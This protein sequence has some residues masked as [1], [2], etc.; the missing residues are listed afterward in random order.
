M[1][2]V[3]GMC[4]VHAC[5]QISAFLLI[6]LVLK[7]LSLNLI[8]LPLSFLP[9]GVSQGSQQ[10]VSQ[11]GAQY[12]TLNVLQQCGNLCHVIGPL[13]SSMIHTYA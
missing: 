10:S 2:C 3:C 9:L 7:M 11:A 4:C 8:Q 12:V 1:L 6:A 5:V 13:A